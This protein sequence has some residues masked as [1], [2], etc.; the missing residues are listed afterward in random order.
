MARVYFVNGQ[1]RPAAKI[2]RDIV[3]QYDAGANYRRDF[4]YALCRLGELKEAD[5]V[6]ARMIRRKQLPG[7]AWYMRHFIAL[8]EGRQADARADLAEAIRLEPANAE[9]R[10]AMGRLDTTAPRR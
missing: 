7:F 3:R 6:F 9:Y 2:L 1:Y 8:Q 4:G 10:E 5:Q